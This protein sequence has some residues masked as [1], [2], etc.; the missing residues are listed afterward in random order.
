MLSETLQRP[1]PGETEEDVLALQEEFLKSGNL[2]SAILVKANDENLGYRGII[3]IIIIV[4][5]SKE[6]QLKSYK[7]QSL[8]D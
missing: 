1:K 6:R 4:N 2:P 5:W 8:A 3:I 7:N